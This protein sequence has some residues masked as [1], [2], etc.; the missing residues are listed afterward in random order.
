MTRTFA[1]R[2]WLSV[3]G[4]AALGRGGAGAAGAL[5]ALGAT[6]TASWRP[7]AHSKAARQAAVNNNTRSFA[8][9]F[10]TS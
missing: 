3:A 5:G 9:I 8:T 10:I 7:Q 6:G 4:T 1:K 2:P